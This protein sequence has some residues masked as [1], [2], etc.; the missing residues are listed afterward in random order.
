MKRT[1]FFLAA[2]A[3]FFY[4]CQHQVSTPSTQGTSGQI[5]DD[6]QQAINND[7]A[8]PVCFESDVLPIFQSSCAKSGCHDVA[9]HK[10]G[11]VLDS[12]KHIMQG[13]GI[14]PGKPFESE[15]FQKIYS[16]EMPPR[17]NTPLT[18]AQ[19]KTIGRWIKQ[20][21]QN[22]TNCGGCDTSQ[23]TYGATIS[24]I[25]QTNCTGCHSGTNPSGGINLS[26]YSGV[27][28]VAL[29]GRLVGA[30]TH[31]PGYSPM[32]KGAA[33]LSDCNITQIEKWVNAGAPNN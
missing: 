33:M 15:I 8:A 25:M 16:G 17:G 23:Y 5:S 11:Y 6:L 4:A 2:G 12:Y 29:N 7:K 27:Q 24:V 1:I 31:A 26:T 28:T 18:D 21:A 9:S 13:E 19:L 3:L 32:P 30:V 20:G 22:T 10:E 14:V